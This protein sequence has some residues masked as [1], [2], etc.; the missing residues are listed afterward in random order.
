[1]TTAWFVGFSPWDAPVICV[2]VVLEDGGHGGAT[3]GPVVRQVLEEY[4]RLKAAREA[5]DL[6]FVD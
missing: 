4:Y 6:F 5:E 2:S 3:A 1:V